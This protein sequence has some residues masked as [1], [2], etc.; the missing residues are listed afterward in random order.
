MAKK[1]AVAFTFEVNGKEHELKLNLE[2]VKYLNRIHEGGAF[3]LIQKA[4]SGD[5]DTYIDIVFASLFHTDKG[6]SRKDIE[7]TIDEMVME[8]KLDLDEINRTTYSVMAESFFYK[9]TLNKVFKHDPEAKKQL[10]DL[11][12]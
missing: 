2:S 1:E 4:L 12:K 3:V 11:M 9:A 6:Y 5:I 8:E 10:E 7:A